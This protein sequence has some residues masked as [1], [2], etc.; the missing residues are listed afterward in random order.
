MQLYFYLLPFITLIWLHLYFRMFSFS[1]SNYIDCNSEWTINCFYYFSAK[2]ISGQSRIS[3]VSILVSDRSEV[4]TQRLGNIKRLLLPD[5]LLISWLSYFL[6]LTLQ[7]SSLFS[8]SSLIWF[9]LATLLYCHAS[10]WTSTLSLAEVVATCGEERLPRKK[11][12]MKIQT[13]TFLHLRRSIKQHIHS[14]CSVRMLELAHCRHAYF[15]NPLP[16]QYAVRRG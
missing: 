12:L 2:V 16:L 4:T 5:Y 13:L 8:M 15:Q 7:T 1:Q 10:C 14:P 9:Y 11:K 3:Q 6:F